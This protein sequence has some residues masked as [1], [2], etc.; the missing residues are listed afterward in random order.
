MDFTAILGVI[1]LL[2]L[3]NVGVFFIFTKLLINTPNAGMK[4]LF[5]N[6]LK[7][8]A[9]LIISLQWLEKTTQHFLV[10]IF[11]FLTASFILYYK[12]IRL[13]NER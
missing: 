11:T 7:D 9:W 3:A 8:I 2:V 12:V 13:L 6:I 1:L 5:V 10:L 4:F